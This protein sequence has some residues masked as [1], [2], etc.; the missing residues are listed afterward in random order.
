MTPSLISTT[1][2]RERSHRLPRLSIVVA[3]LNTFW[4]K[5]YLITDFW[6]LNFLINDFRGYTLMITD[7]W[8]NFY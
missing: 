1:G 6:A 2:A 4:A 8:V 5:M 3:L 7:V